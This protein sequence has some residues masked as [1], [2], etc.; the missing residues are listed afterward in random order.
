MFNSLYYY[1]YL[2]GLYGEKLDNFLLENGPVDGS[3]FSWYACMGVVCVISSLVVSAI[4]Y[5]VL[6]PVRRQMFWWLI[7]A[8]INIVINIFSALY[9]SWSPIINNEVDSNE[10][11]SG[12]DILG[13]CF[14]N[15]IW[16]FIFFIIVALI[17]KWKSTA[18]YVPFKKF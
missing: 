4:F 14:A 3:D 6:A 1:T 10:L 2:L 15:A 18:K 7:Y 13:L 16:S 8:L 9:F 17:I 5:Y 12:F 11:W